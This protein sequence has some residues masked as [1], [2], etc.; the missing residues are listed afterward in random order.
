MQVGLSGVGKLFSAEVLTAMGEANERPIIM[1][2]SNPIS[3]LECTHASAQQ[4]TGSSSRLRDKR[5]WRGWGM[6]K[7]P[8]PGGSAC[9][10]DKAAAAWRSGEVQQQACLCMCWQSL[11]RHSREP[12]A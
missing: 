1:A 10:W 6:V 5:V 8:S 3:R 2:M 12:Q 11:L 7:G 4:H 9:V